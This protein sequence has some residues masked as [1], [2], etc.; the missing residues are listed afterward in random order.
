MDWELLKKRWEWPAWKRKSARAADRSTRTSVPV[1]I[2]ARDAPTDRGCRSG[3]GEL[4]FRWPSEGTVAKSARWR[5]GRLRANIPAMA[6][7]T[8]FPAGCQSL[9]WGARRH[10]ILNLL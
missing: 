9:A 5:R 1:S 2:I 7:G 6:R 8:T 4:Y 10:L 3:A